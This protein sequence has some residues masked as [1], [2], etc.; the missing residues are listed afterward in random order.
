VGRDAVEV[1]MESY[2]VMYEN[3]KKVA[4]LSR[5]DVEK[6]SVRELA[7]VIAVQEVLGRTVEYEE[8]Q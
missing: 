4:E 8:R 1:K 5:H 7:L 2:L 3:G 6:H